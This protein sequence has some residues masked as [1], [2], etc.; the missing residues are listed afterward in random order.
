M[1][2]DSYLPHLVTYL[3]RHGHGKLKGRGERKTAQQLFN[4]E[5]PLPTGHE[6]EATL[7]GAVRANYTAARQLVGRGRRNRPTKS[8]GWRQI[9]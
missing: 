9:G 5:K 7:L 8:P 6:K 1:R 3:L 2:L 4:L